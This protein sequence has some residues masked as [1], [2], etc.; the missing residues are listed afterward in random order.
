[1][2]TQPDARTRLLRA[3]SLHRLVGLE[4]RLDGWEPETDRLRVLVPAARARD[5]DAWLRRDGW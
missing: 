4:A 3:A 1:M 2:T 5:L